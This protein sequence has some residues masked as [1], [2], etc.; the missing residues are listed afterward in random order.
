MWMLFALS[1]STQ[2]GLLI[3]LDETTGRLT[4]ICVDGGEIPLLD[5]AWGG[6][7]AHEIRPPEKGKSILLNGDL[8][9][10]GRGNPR[11]WRLQGKHVK[12]DSTVNHTP[13]GRVSGKVEL[14]PEVDKQHPA[15]SG[16][17]CSQLIPAVPEAWYH[18]SA[19]GR[20]K[21]GGS[22]GNVFVRELD[23]SG[24]IL[25]E[26]RFHVQHGLH[27][28]ADESGKWVRK[29]KVFR[30]KPQCRFLQ[31]YAN[32][33][34]GW[35]TF[36]FDDVR[37]VQIGF[38]EHELRGEVR[39]EGEALVQRFQ[40]GDDGK[41]RMEVRYLARPRYLF[42]KAELRDEASPPRERCFRIVFSLPIDAEG[43]RW[44]DDVRF[45]E[46]IERG[47][48]YQHCFRMRHGREI[49]VY[50]LA[51][52]SGPKAGL[53][54]AVR[55]DEPRVQKF[56]YDPRRGLCTSFD[57]GLSPLTK[58][59]G[60]GRAWFS[61]LIFRHDPKWG[62]RSAL[63][64]YYEFFPQ[65]FVKRVRK[66]GLWF[67]AV[68]IKPIPHPE[69]FGLV[70]YEGFRD[71]D[72]AHRKGILI[73]PYIEPWGLRQPFPKVERREDMPPY[74]ERLRRLREW[75]ERPS[76][77]K[78]A[79]GPQQEVAR[80]ILNSLPLL[81]DGKAPYRVDKYAVWAQWWLTN[82][83][84]DL[85]LPNRAS[86]CK[87]YRVDP[88]LHVADGIY[89]D[90][91]SLR[92]G[93]YENCRPEHIACADHPL[94]FS[95]ETGRPVLVGFISH[96]E[97]IEWLANYLHERGKLVLMNLFPYAYRFYAHFG[98]IIGSEVGSGGRRRNLADVEP[99]ERCNVRRTLAYKKPV[100][101]LLQE[102][103]FHKPVP[104]LSQEEVEQYIKHQMFYGFYPGIATIGGEERPGYIGWKRYFGAPEQYERDRELFKRYIPVIRALSRAGWE[105]ITGAKTSD[106]FVF[107]ERFGEASAGRVFFTL[108]NHSQKLR[109]FGVRME[110]STLGIPKGAR[111]TVRD[112]LRR[113]IIPVRVDDGEVSFRFRLKGKDTAVVEL[114]IR[115][116]ASSAKGE[117]LPSIR[118]V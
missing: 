111:V 66:E 21:E 9:E 90:S 70:Y 109:E 86:V 35:G 63:K 11:G 47:R 12:W 108:R 115:K 55:M 49:S 81:S 94:A 33:W 1:L 113:A 14:P 42:V 116:A 28:R 37:L 53:S 65:F 43:W 95:L 103:N 84:P 88:F 5:N 15:C 110:R 76:E 93:D 48:S 64:R 46:R 75:A 79:G 3:A 62:F 13:G 82:T 99:P 118:E 107:V 85:P 18:I 60:P 38:V 40:L 30:T 74:E 117:P 105:P 114:T 80:A 32:I 27:W 92:L 68:P 112:V 36:W 52:V 16:S 56:W 54:L 57:L 102:G 25:W 45:G 50:P 6:F 98:D 101:N 8:E 19:W 23:E 39:R 2:D 96:Y 24:E 41:V 22:G 20:V 59:F 100:C 91:V 34:K 17:L 106:P 89:F 67:Y 7:S 97:F 73:F 69:D 44:H 104:P 4:K 31:V 29:S 71:V 51:S 26:G 78:W 87:K 58:K 83:D 77:K 72:Y 61:F 10:W